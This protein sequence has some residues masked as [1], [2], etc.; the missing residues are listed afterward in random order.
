MFD[1]LIPLAPDDKFDSS[2]HA[3][4]SLSS[5]GAKTQR[6]SWSYNSSAETVGYVAKESIAF[7]NKTRIELA[8]GEISSPDYSSHLISWTRAVT[9]DLKRGKEYCFED[10]EIRPAYYRPFYKQNLLWYFPLVE[11]RYRVPP[12]YPC[13][14]A[15]N[16]CICV[17][18]VGVNKAFSCII[19]NLIPD[20]EVIGKSQCFPLYWYEENQHQEAT[21]FGD[22][23]DEKYIRHDGVTDWVLKEFRKR[24]PGSKNLTKEHIFYY[25]YGILHSPDYK[26]R[27]AADLKKSLPRIPIV[28]TVNELMDFYNAGKAL[29]DLHLKYESVEP[30]KEVKVVCDQAIDN[31]NYGLFEVEKMRFGKD[32]KDTDKSVIIYNGHIRL[33]NIPEKAYEYVVNGKSAIEWIME[34]YAVTVDKASLIKNDPNDWSREHKKPRYILD[35]LLSIINVS[36]KSMEIIEKLPK[37]SF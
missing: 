24:F 20:L 23:S 14:D 33:E 17:S 7:Y 12:L 10:A 13:R 1:S 35:L 6:D 2:A 25:V 11:M 29:A 34:R 36:V 16:F 31:S 30:C 15:E 5:N 26:E 8:K 22:G 19:T 32:G 37:L 9:N 18:G 3:F 21:L 27:F 28:E 4:F